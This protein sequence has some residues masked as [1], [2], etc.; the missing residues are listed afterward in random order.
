MITNP[1]LYIAILS[2]CRG[3]G[4]QINGIFEV[5]SETTTSAL[6]ELQ[7]DW[8]MGRADQQTFESEMTF[9]SRYMIIISSRVNLSFCCRENQSRK[10][11]HV[12]FLTNKG[13]N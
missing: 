13:H 12:I 5:F 11:G 3:N 4:N 1:I 7:S 6:S 2:N 8:F 10:V 9:I